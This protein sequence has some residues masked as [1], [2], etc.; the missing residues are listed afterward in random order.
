MGEFHRCGYKFDRW[1]N[2]IWMKKITGL[3]ETKKEIRKI[4]F[5]GVDKRWHRLFDNIRRKG[6]I[7]TFLSDYE[8]AKEW[9]L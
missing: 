4:V 1:Y 6:K 7:I 8:K 5:V 3:I 2:M 9:L